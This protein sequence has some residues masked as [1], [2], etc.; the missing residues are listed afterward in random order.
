MTELMHTFMRRSISL[1]NCELRYDQ[2]TKEW[3]GIYPWNRHVKINVSVLD[4]NKVDDKRFF[5][6]FQDAMT[7]KSEN[8][9]PPPYKYI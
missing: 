8:M 7:L 9:A 4:K 6:I 1:L 3:R 5:G 2:G